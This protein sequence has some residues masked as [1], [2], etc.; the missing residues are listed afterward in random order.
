MDTKTMRILLI[1]K[2]HYKKGGAERAYF[3]TARILA[4]N[5]HSVAFFSMEHSDNLATPWSKYFVSPVD[6]LDEKQSVWKKIQAAFSIIWNFEAARNLEALIVEFGPEV[7][8]LHNTYHQLSPSIL[9]VLKRHRIPVVMTLHDYKAVSPNYSLFVRGKIW[10]HTS[11]F[12]TIIDRAIKDSFLKSMVCALELWFHKLIGSY[13][14]VD[15]FIAPSQ[16]LI[17]KYKELGFP[18]AIQRI[19]QPLSP[20]P[21]RP[22]VFGSGKYFLFAG[23]L[24]SEKGA[25]TLLEVFSQIPEERLLVA[26]TGPDE[27]RLKLAYGRCK[28][29][30][31]LGHLTGKPLEKIFHEAKAF[32]L[33]SEWYENMPYSLLEALS[34][35]L[36]V[37]G[38]RLGG[39]VERIREGENGFL[40]EPGSADDLR[41]ALEIF[42][43]THHASMGEAAWESIQDLQEGKYYQVLDALYRRL[44]DSKKI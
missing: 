29:I 44:I 25:E 42:K 10:E 41:Q 24:S 38:S 21:G 12:R 19:A 40:F 35:G 33:P 28:N 7:A 2:H 37:I 3:D 39:T 9:W 32:V 8:H 34:F 18:Y 15:Q 1:N 11:G 26:G 14:L 23:R 20:F 43:R 30:Q 6:Y 16:F 5:G 27:E 17:D 31:F 22:E 36:P 13:K 4:E